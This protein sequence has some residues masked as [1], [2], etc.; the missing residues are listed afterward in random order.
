[1]MKNLLLVVAMVALLP[2]IGTAQAM[3]YETYGVL[4]NPHTHW[5]APVTL[6]T[7]LK[8]RTLSDINSRHK[9]EW[10]SRYKEVAISS[11]C[12]GQ[13]RKASSPNNQLNAEQL[14]LLKA[15]HPDCL[16]EVDIHYIPNN[17]LQDNPA[18]TMNAVLTVVPI[19]EAK[20]PGGYLQ[21]KE[22][23]RKNIISQIPTEVELAKVRYTVDAHGQA[24]DVNFL[25]S[26]GEKAVDQLIE[27]AICNMPLWTPAENLDGQRITQEFELTLGT[28]MLRCDFQYE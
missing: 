11:T 23:L 28:M 8:A 1:M 2:F 18:R 21:L 6:D 9:N 13:T 22:Y 7:L 15:A 5:Y 12:N 17:N 27:K 4:T 16:V 24:T 20:F 3:G 19:K 25:T 14:N 26:S 10:V